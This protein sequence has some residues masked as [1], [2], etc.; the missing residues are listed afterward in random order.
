MIK[1]VRKLFWVWDFEEEEAWLNKMADEGWALCGV[2][3]CRYDFEPTKPGEY[4]IRLE[5]LENHP[6]THESADYINFMKSTGAECVASWVRWTYFRKKRELGEFDL[7]SDLDSRIAHLTRIITM[8]RIIAG[9]ELLIAVSNLCFSFS[10][11]MSIINSV[12]SVI[13]AVMAAVLFYGALRL[14]RRKNQL[15]AERRIHE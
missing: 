13:C 8:L 10:S 6:T 12:C 11:P 7:F 15:E 4:A 1:R 3:W 2:G 14:T 9:G 5:L